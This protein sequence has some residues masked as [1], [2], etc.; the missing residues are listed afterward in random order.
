MI[1]NALP[2]DIVSTSSQ[3]CRP[4]ILVSFRL[5]TLLLNSKDKNTQQ[6]RYNKRVQR[7]QKMNKCAC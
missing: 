1:S 2:S 7:L 5:L 6:H 4:I 3:K